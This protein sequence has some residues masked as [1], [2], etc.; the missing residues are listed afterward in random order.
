MTFEQRIKRTEKLLEM[1]SRRAD[2]LKKEGK[3]LTDPYA[4]SISKKIKSLNK[5]MRK[6]KRIQEKAKKIEEKKARAASSPPAS[7]PAS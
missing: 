1:L 4:H 5:K 3:K 7:P 6:F 2:E